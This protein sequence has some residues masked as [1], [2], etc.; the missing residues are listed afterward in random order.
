MKSWLTGKPGLF[1]I[2]AIA[3]L[4]LFVNQWLLQ[5]ARLDLTED[6]Q[7][8]LS[9][10]TR[11]IIA[12]LKQPVI[13]EFY[14]SNQATRDMP[15]LRNYAQRIRE[16]L[17][18]YDRIGNGKIRLRV[19]NPEPFSEAEDKAVER[20]LR[21]VRLAPGAPEVYFG[22]VALA[23]KDKSTTIPF[24]NQERDSYLEYDISEL[25]VQVSRDHKPKIALYAEPD[26]LVQGGINPFN[27]QPQPPWV[28]V[29]QIQR[30][31]DVTWLPKD[32]KA[33]PK[34]TE[35]LLL[36]HPRSLEQ[37][38]LYAID[39]YL[40]RG[41]RSLFFV[42]PY[43]ELD[44]P[45]AFVQPGRKKNSDLN[46]LFK[47]WGFEMIPGRFVGDNKY[48]MPV[49]VAEGRPAVRHLGLLGLDSSAFAD[50]PI[51]AHLDKLLLSSAGALSPLNDSH[52]NFLPLLS[53]SRDAMLIPTAALDYLFDPGILYDAFQA[54]GK[55]HILAARI[56]GK[57]P[58]AFAKP[59]SPENTATHVSQGKQSAQLIVVADSDLLANRLWAKIQKS[60]DGE[61][62]I[63]PVAD[64]GPFV[65]NA[66]DYL[67]G[68]P[69][70]IS[71]RSHAN[72]AKPFEKV[73]N[74]RRQA[75]KALREKVAQLQQQLQATEKKMA[76]LE[77]A[78]QT[79]NQ[80]L[81]PQQQQTLETFQQQRLQIRKDLR[82]LQHQLNEDIERLGNWLKFIN[83]LLLPL[84]LTALLL[85]GRWWKNRY[86]LPAIQNIP[87]SK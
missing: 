28:I 67:T 9:K 85:L 2:A 72:L 52:L 66:I 64:N 7:Y 5:G 10:G 39:Q 21:P 22:L 63:V 18:E 13:L 26:L 44:G 59:P 65:I 6:K 70:L 58:S 29:E 71:I 17:Q 42:D 87:T 32:F 84:M 34:E 30:F 62:M 78:K 16:L 49:K 86:R 48:A 46:P 4:A 27:R 45:P 20:G 53:S 47:A 43:A 35:L 69:D 1:L 23:G 36:I 51:L 61:R 77:A 31:Y 54:D 41:G 33:I 74:L 57:F 25:L 75:E 40:L 81:T 79:P 82:H 60:P 55:N 83:I 8:T 3:V 15:L 73:E 68:N 12:S 11:N 76:A 38:A 56:E 80:N 24:F 37:P 19:I 50:E 14:F